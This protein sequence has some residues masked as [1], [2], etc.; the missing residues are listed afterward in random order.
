MLSALT[1]RTVINEG[2][3]GEIS[4]GGL[5]RLPGVLDKYS[6]D[7]L[8]LIHGGNDL[9]RGLDQAQI[10]SNLG[11]MIRLARERGVPVVMLGVPDRSLFLSSA[12]LYQSLAEE[13]SA[14]IDTR[15]LP[16]ILSARS[17]K[18]DLIHPNDRGYRMMAEA[19]YRLLDESGGL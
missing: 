9:L 14:P 7:L 19:V 8:I 13:W 12:E 3:P 4:G 11:A 6:P 16:E 2:R 10:R 5:R 1:G 17:L 18:S 15:T